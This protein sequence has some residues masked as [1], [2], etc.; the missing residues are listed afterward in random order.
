MSA[1]A[2]AGRARGYFA[3]RIDASAACRRGIFRGILPLVYVRSIPLFTEFLFAYQGKISNTHQTPTLVSLGIVG[4]MGR[5]VMP[6]GGINPEGSTDHGIRMYTLGYTASL[7]ILHLSVTGHNI[8]CASLDRLAL[9]PGTQYAR[10][11][12]EPM[13]ASTNR[14]KN[15]DN[16]IWGVYRPDQGIAA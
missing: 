2:G 1:R 9:S 13:G 16:L 12:G 3:Q 11:H 14:H 6:S 10:F 15:I 4:W 5:S 8:I 7:S